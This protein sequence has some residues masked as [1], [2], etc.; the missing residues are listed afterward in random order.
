M[1]GDC[2]G[3]CDGGHGIGGSDGSCVI[4]HRLDGHSISQADAGEERRWSGCAADEQLCHAIAGVTEV[5]GAFE[6]SADAHNEHG[7]IVVGVL[8]LLELFGRASLEI[9]SLT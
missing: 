8:P 3:D 4:E 5:V 6:H 9:T 7:D 2:G 1:G